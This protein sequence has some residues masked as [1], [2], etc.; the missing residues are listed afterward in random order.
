MLQNLP[1]KT[2]GQ[3]VNFWC[4]IMSPKAFCSLTDARH[5]IMLKDREKG[6]SL[7]E[8]LLVVV[9]IGVVAALAVPAF[10]RATR[11]AEN[12]AV[13]STLRVIASTQVAFFTQN[14]RFG[15]LAEINQVVGNSLGT[16][17]SD[18]LVRGTFVFEMTPVV[19]TDAELRTEYLITATLNIP[20]E[21][22]YQYELNQSG[23]IE[24][25]RP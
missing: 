4:Q 13:F 3:T 5:V 18:R 2:V 22:I 15:R 24:Q 6:F 1:I 8:L 17:T 14:S 25:I 12:G 7:I 10:Q 20:G 16:N 9:V 19:P 23:E 11:A 21:T